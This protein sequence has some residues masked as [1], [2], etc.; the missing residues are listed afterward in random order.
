MRNDNIRDKCGVQDVAKWPRAGRRH[1]KDHV[2]RMQN[3]RLAKIVKDQTPS[4]RKPVGRPPKRWKESW[5]STLG[6]T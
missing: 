3:I 4:T 5:I 6:K 1:W 2:D